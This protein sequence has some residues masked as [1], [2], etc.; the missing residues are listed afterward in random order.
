LE[1]ITF[2][3]TDT[4][5]IRE[6]GDA[7]E[8]MSI[9]RTFRTLR[10]AS[11]ALWVIDLTSEPGHIAS[12]AQTVVPH[13]EGKQ[14]LLL[15][16]KTDLLAPPSLAKQKR[17]LMDV[18]AERLYISAKRQTGI[19]RLKES[20]V[21]AAALPE[22]QAG[23]VIVTNVRHYEALVRAGAA[24]LRVR[25]GLEENVSGDLLGQDIREAIHYIGEITGRIANDEILGNIFSRFCIGK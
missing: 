19:S 11:V 23:D 7:V 14:T 17:L 10:Q 24:L 15:F 8:S 3:F 2:R 9:E 20:L 1:G 13:L 18:P 21:R 22:I 25:G 16:N 6:T 5:G 12:I 4:A